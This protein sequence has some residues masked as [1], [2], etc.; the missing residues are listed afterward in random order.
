MAA[1][2]GAARP[3]ALILVLG[4]PRVVNLWKEGVDCACPG[5][6][7]GEDKGQCSSCRLILSHWMKVRCVYLPG[8]WV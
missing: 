2:C 6:G 5:D 1:L 4:Q 8:E 7:S 3:S